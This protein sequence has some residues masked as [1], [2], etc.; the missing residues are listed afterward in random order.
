MVPLVV[1]AKKLKKC[2]TLSTTNYR[3]VNGDLQQHLKDIYAND[4]H[5]LIKEAV[6]KRVTKQEDWVVW[7]HGLEIY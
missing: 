1:H 5:T 2:T 3:R 4:L 6:Y 7:D